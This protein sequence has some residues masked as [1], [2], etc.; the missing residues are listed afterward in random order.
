MISSFGVIVTGFKVKDDALVMGKIIANKTLCVLM[1][2]KLMRLQRGRHEVKLVRYPEEQRRRLLS[3]SDIRVRGNDKA[4]RP[5]TRGG[6]NHQG[7][8]IMN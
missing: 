3:L 2:K 4:E 6:G 8:R 5:I 7:A 1:V